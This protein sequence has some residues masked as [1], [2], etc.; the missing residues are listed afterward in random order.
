MHL[1]AML[2][3]L[4]MLVAATL[5]S[6]V[7]DNRMVLK[8]ELQTCNQ[9]IQLAGVPVAM[10]WTVD[11]TIAPVSVTVH[12]SPVAACPGRRVLVWVLVMFL[13]LHNLTIWFRSRLKDFCFY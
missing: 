10:I 4:I 5:V 7:L 1:R 11:C 8:P 2:D 13:Q 12:S 6:M 3:M 9:M